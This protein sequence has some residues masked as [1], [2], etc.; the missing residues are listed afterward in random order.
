MHAHLEI[1]KTL[2]FGHFH[3]SSMHAK[4]ARIHA[5]I[6][7]QIHTCVYTCMHA[8]K[9]ACTNGQS[10]A[11]CPRKALFHTQQKQCG[12][13]HTRSV[14]QSSGAFTYL[15][16]SHYRGRVA[17]CDHRCSTGNAH[18]QFGWGRNLLRLTT[19][20]IAHSSCPCPVTPRKRLERQR[21]PCGDA[22]RAP[23][24]AARV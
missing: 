2:S 11:I 18:F 21:K 4:Y 5:Y 13:G 7:E 8:D 16:T 3:T 20:N 24:R 17:L 12:M 19:S 6:G 9:H 22:A 10:S 1:R 15:L 23:V 14:E